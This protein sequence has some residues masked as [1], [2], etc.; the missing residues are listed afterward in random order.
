MRSSLLRLL[1]YR[2]ALKVAAL[3]PQTVI[4]AEDPASRRGSWPSSRTCAGSGRRSESS[5]TTTWRLWQPF[6]PPTQPAGEFPRISPLSG[7]TISFAAYT[8]PGLTSVAQPKPELGALAV[9]L[10]LDGDH[11]AAGTRVLDGHLVVR[12]STA[13]GD[14]QSTR[15]TRQSRTADPA[16]HRA[17]A[18]AR[19][20]ERAAHGEPRAT[21]RQPGDVVGNW[22]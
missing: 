20:D 2:R 19:A 7:L 17:S 8:N 12:Q 14:E 10:V 9:D 22:I 4:T 11:G 18:P 13:H 1:G 6:A 21:E 5:P 15:R 3:W 16:T